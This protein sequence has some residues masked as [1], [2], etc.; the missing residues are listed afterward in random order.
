MGAD[1]K[2]PVTSRENKRKRTANE[3]LDLDAG[4]PKTPDRFPKK[5][6]GSSSS[7]NAL[8]SPPNAPYSPPN[9]GLYFIGENFLDERVYLSDKERVSATEEA[10][11]PAP[12]GKW[13]KRQTGPGKGVCVTARLL[14]GNNVPRTRKI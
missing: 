12:Y 4:T 7:P 1:M 10:N 6:K 2:A 11:N 14:N 9:A 13:A 3:P 8:Y 5:P